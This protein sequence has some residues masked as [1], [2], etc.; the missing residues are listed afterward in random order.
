MIYDARAETKDLSWLGRDEGRHVGC[1]ESFGRAEGFRDGVEAR[2]K[3]G[4]GLAGEDGERTLRGPAWVSCDFD[5]IANPEL[6]SGSSEGC[7]RVG[8]A[9]VI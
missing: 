1:M 5:S 9:R 7:E 6:F 8:L 3:D 2:C 4:N